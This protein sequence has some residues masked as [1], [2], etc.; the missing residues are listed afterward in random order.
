MFAELQEIDLH[1]NFMK[2]LCNDAHKVVASGKLHATVAFENVVQ[3]CSQ[4]CKEQCVAC[5]NSG[6]CLVIGIDRSFD[7]RPPRRCRPRCALGGKPM[8][9]CQLPLTT[10]SK[11]KTASDDSDCC[12]QLVYVSCLPQCSA[13]GVHCSTLP[14]IS[15]RAAA[16]QL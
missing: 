11:E 8:R 15:M 14:C 16:A 3:Q 12:V 10:V 7:G 1:S 13:C 5:Y 6:C 2:M 9:L 4:S